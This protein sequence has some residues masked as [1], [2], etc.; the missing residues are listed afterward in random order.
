MSWLH[1]SLRRDD[2]GSSKTVFDERGQPY[3]LYS[4]ACQCENYKWIADKRFD[5]FKK[6]AKELSERHKLR[7]RDP[8]QDPEPPPPEL[9]RQIVSAGWLTP[10]SGVQNPDFVRKRG[11]GLETWLANCVAVLPEGDD[12][13]LD[14][15]SA[16]AAV[17]RSFSGCSQPSSPSKTTRGAGDQLASSGGGAA[18]AAAAVERPSASP[19]RSTQTSSRAAALKP[20]R[21]GLTWEVVWE[22][23]PEEEERVAAWLQSASEAD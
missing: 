23:P 14:A 10:L 2:S 8:E 17:P 1:V 3:T 5:D 16:P 19:S 18:S 11:A 4:F 15:L 6:L 22:A 12:L 9:P 7:T 13:L 20:A 21:P